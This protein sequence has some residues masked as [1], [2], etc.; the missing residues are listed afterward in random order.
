[1][2][3]QARVILGSD[4]TVAGSRWTLWSDGSAV[5]RYWAFQ[6]VEGEPTRWLEVRY[7]SGPTGH[8]VWMEAR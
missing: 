8:K 7:V 6:R 1:M 3:Q 4:I 2:A 5:G